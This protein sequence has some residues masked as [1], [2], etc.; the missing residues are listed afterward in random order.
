MEHILGRKLKKGEI[1]HHVD[2]NK[3]NNTPSNLELTN[4]IEHGRLHGQ[5]LA[6]LKVRNKK[7]MFI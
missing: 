4:R 1:V 6:K 5:E 7:G 3:R 2:G